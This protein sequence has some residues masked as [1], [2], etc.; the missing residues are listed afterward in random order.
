MREPTRLDRRTTWRRW[1]SPRRVLT[2]L[3]LLAAIGHPAVRAGL[4]APVLQYLNIS[5]NTFT[6][7]GDVTYSRQVIGCVNQMPQ[8]VAF[9]APVHLPQGAIVRS[10]RLQTY[11]DP[12]SA[13]TSTASL[14][15]DDGKGNGGIALT[16][17]SRANVAGFQANDSPVTPLTIDNKRNSYVVEWRKD[18]GANSNL[19]SLCGIRIAYRLP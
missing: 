2:S 14:I 12:A 4:A 6:P 13:A 1:R 16:V 15:V 7:A 5:G 19:L 17:K 8:N 9:S 18:F 3:A 11:D 10:I